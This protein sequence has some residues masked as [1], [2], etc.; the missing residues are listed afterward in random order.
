[1]KITLSAL[2]LACAASLFLA[3]AGARPQEG[4]GVR[5]DSADPAAWGG[6]SLA[7]RVRALL[8]ASGVEV[9]AGITFEHRSRTLQPD[10]PTGP[11]GS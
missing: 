3:A 4:A 2:G 11:A 7:Q 8:S 6:A 10:D 5:Q 9:A 1:M